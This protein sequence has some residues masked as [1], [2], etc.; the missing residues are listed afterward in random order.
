MKVIVRAKID[1]LFSPAT[2]YLAGG[3]ER[4]FVTGRNA[5]IRKN[6]Y[7]TFVYVVRSGAQRGGGFTV[8][9]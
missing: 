1:R 3:A 8:V 7:F 2:D 4:S 9:S 5:G 6:A